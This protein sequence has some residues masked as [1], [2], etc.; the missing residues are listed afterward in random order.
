MNY[1]CK[2][3]TSVGVFLEHRISGEL[4]YYQGCSNNANLF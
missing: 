1:R 4:R 2:V 3:S